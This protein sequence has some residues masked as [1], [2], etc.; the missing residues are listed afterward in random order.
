M[1][2]SKP[3][4]S[5]RLRKNWG[6]SSRAIVLDVNLWMGTFAVRV[7]IPQRKKVGQ[8][9]GK[10]PGSGPTRRRRG[11][12]GRRTGRARV[13]KTRRLARSAARDLAKESCPVKKGSRTSLL[14]RSRRRRANW[15][16]GR[17]AFTADRFRERVQIHGG[18]EQTDGTMPDL[19]LWAVSGRYDREREGVMRFLGLRLKA[20]AKY[21]RQK[22]FP[23]GPFL[24]DGGR[25]DTWGWFRRF[26]ELKYGTW[27]DVSWQNRSVSDR[28]LEFGLLSDGEH[29]YPA[30]ALQPAVLTRQEQASLDEAG[31]G[32]TGSSRDRMALHRSN[33]R[34]GR[35]STHPSRVTRE[36]RREERDQLSSV[37]RDIRE[38]TRRRT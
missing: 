32:V 37:L 7:D 24:R 35:G 22:R 30:Y 38:A 4:L 31:R 34:R 36:N 29:L 10:L 12:R 2:F 26:W 25:V 3:G 15:I 19:Q 20:L 18:F 6:P 17:F 11:S 13:G 14:A 28:T 9:G 5:G 1:A 16:E 27:E 33:A 23:C 8:E 21:L